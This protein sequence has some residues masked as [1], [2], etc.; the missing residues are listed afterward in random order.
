MI[1]AF[2][3]IAAD[4]LRGG[5]LPLRHRHIGR[6]RHLNPETIGIHCHYTL[7]TKGYFHINLA[8]RHINLQL[9]LELNVMVAIDIITGSD[10]GGVFYC[11]SIPLYHIG[12]HTGYAVLPHK[13]QPVAVV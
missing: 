9:L 11:N 7:L 4:I 3:H 5:I 8:A 6:Q 12:P 10:A 2:A 13:H 1:G